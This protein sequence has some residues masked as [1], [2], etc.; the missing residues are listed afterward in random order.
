ML[1]LI[2]TAL[3]ALFIIVIALYRPGVDNRRILFR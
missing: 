1:S 3:L 2:L